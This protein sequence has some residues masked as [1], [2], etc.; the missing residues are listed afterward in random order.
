[1]SPQ[2]R[3][4]A[5]NWAACASD[6]ERM[7]GYTRPEIS[8]RQAKSDQWHQVEQKYAD[9]VNGKTTVVNGVKG[10]VRKLEPTTMPSVHPIPGEHERAGPHQQHGIIEPHGPKQHVLDKIRRHR[11]SPIPKA[12]P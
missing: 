5:W 4:R 9:L 3:P 10:L 11:A 12:T 8:G 6:L 2:P 7:I 1:V